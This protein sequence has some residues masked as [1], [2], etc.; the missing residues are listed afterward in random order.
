MGS[1][2]SNTPARKSGIPSPSLSR[3]E[4]APQPA[5]SGSFCGS[6]ALVLAGLASCHP[7]FVFPHGGGADFGYVPGVRVYRRAQ[8][9]PPPLCLGTALRKNRPLVPR[10]NSR[11]TFFCHGIGFFMVL[12]DAGQLF[13]CA[14][15]HFMCVA[16]GP[17]IRGDPISQSQAHIPLP[18]ALNPKQPANDQCVDIIWAKAAKAARAVWGLAHVFNN[19]LF[20]TRDI[21]VPPPPPC[22]SYALVQATVG[23]G[24][25]LIWD[26][27]LIRYQ[28]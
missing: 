25:V 14:G 22:I 1:S 15:Q 21:M 11:T 20:F 4:P 7:S 23:V 5:V 28:T 8:V 17:P 9:V 2:E 10:S 13:R 24:T 12:L 27:I 6:Y 16:T 19:K 3:A 18:P 26:L